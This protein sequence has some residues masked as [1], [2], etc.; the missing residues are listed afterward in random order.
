MVVGALLVQQAKCALSMEKAVADLKDKLAH[1]QQ[2]VSNSFLWVANLAIQCSFKFK[3]LFEITMLS[4]MRVCV[5]LIVVILLQSSI[6][7][8]LAR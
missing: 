7:I 1:H 8:L 4:L 2:E 6:T 5:G 3:M